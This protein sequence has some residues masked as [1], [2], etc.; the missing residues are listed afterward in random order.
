MRP[1]HV[2]GAHDFVGFARLQNAVLMN[3]GGMGKGVRAHYG[4]V[5]LHG[6]TGDGTHQ[7]TCGHDLRRIDVRL[8]VKEVASGFDRHHHFFQGTVAGAFAQAVDRA[9]NLARAARVH[10]CQGIRDRHSE[11]VV[12][13]HGPNRLIG[14]RHLFPKVFEKGPI[15]F[16]HRVA[17]GIGNVDGGGAGG[18]HGFA[19]AVEEFWFGSI[20]VFSREF[21]VVRVLRAG[22]HRSD[23]AFKHFVRRHPQFRLHMQGTRRNERMNT[24]ARCEFDGFTRLFNVFQRRTGERADRRILHVTCNLFDRFKVALGAR[25]KPRFHHIDPEALQLQGDP[26]LFFLRHRGT[27]TLFPVTQRGIKNNEAV[28]VHAHF[29]QGLRCLRLSASGQFPEANFLSLGL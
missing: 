13:V 10:A 28:A 22:L 29:S 24:A 25:R 4:L 1:T 5:G 26:K 3:A 19:D 2:F 23:R 16:R 15:E 20:P 9:F 17:H 8:K 14:I 12:A 21:N 6:E 11:V 7:L 27:G 18:N